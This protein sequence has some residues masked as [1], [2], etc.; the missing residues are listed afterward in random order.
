M[1]HI[2]K[3][4][5]NK[6]FNILSL[7]GGGV[8]GIF[9]S[10]FLEKL[11]KEL[12]LPLNESFDL[13]CGTST[14]SIVGMAAALNI[15][16]RLVTSLYNDKSNLIFKKTRFGRFT[17]GPI[18]SQDALKKELNTVFDN[19]LLKDIG[20]KVIITSASLASLEFTT[21]SNFPTNVNVDDSLS[22]VEAILS[23]TAAPT[24]FMPF[25]PNTHKGH[26]V[27]G[28]V[29]ANNPSV[30]AML[31][32]H[33]YLNIPYENIRM[34]SIGTGDFR[35]G[36]PKEHFEEMRTWGLQTTPT[37]LD[38]FFSTQ[39]SFADLHCK[40]VL[41]NN[42]IKISTNLTKK[43]ELDDTKNSLELLPK[44]AEEEFAKFSTQI[45]SLI[46][47][48][49]ENQ[50]SIVSNNN[51]DSIKLSDNDASAWMKNNLQNAVRKFYI[52]LG[53][54][55]F[56]N[57]SINRLVSGIMKDDNV[58][59][60]H[61]I[62]IENNKAANQKYD[63][64][65]ND[66]FMKQGKTACIKENITTELGFIE[67]NHFDKCVKN[68]LNSIG[69]TIDSPAEQIFFSGILTNKDNEFKKLENFTEYEN[70]VLNCECIFI[71]NDGKFIKIDSNKTTIFLENL[72]INL[73][74]D[75]QSLLHITESLSEIPIEDQKS[76]ILQFKRKIGDQI[77]FFEKKYTLKSK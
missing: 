3:Q 61:V 67:R 65:L 58:W 70:E 73:T 51:H 45:K 26:Y 27:D 46:L 29:W 28:G 55:E 59:D 63:I 6:T 10:T 30:L 8:R 62:I 33:K 75:Y 77:K 9:Q 48:N 19:K 66:F 69:V 64:F 12:G 49:N 56:E 20:T 16:L 60:W 25:K 18:Y 2:K 23:S 43:I 41:G 36:Y 11:T 4:K 5:E 22:I 31:Y 71:G 52:R 15:D 47:R 32:A 40:E 13:I 14:G 24:Y 57:N 17:K 1:Q 21:F 44:L 42:F 76:T 35:T 72:I 37:L 34:L 53:H 68:S 39:S 50:L 38:L 7:C 54:Y 74:K